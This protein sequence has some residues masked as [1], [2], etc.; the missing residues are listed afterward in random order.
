MGPDLVKTFLSVR[1]KFV[2]FLGKVVRSTFH[3]IMNLLVPFV[4]YVFIFANSLVVSK[5]SPWVR[6]R[7]R[8]RVRV[9]D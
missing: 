6:V 8:V 9:L 5:W 3:A 7:V 1:I 2:C 4:W